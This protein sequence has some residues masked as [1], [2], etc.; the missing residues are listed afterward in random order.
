VH[1]MFVAGLFALSCSAA[2]AAEVINV[3]FKFTPFV[4]NPISEDQVKTVAGTARIFVNGIPYAEQEVGE[5]DVPVMFDER[6]IAAAVWLPTQSCG[7]LLRKGKNTIRIE[8]EPAD[9][10]LLYRAQFR[11]AAVMDEST[12]ASSDGSYAAT[13]QSGE[14]GEEKEGSGTLAFEREFQADFAVDQPWHHAPPVTALDEGDRKALAALVT[15]RVEAFQ[16]DFA[17][18]YALLEGR[19]GIDVAALKEAKC[20]DKAYEAGARIASPPA[21]E[22]DFLVTGNPEVVIRAKQGNLFF[23]ADVSAFQRITDE[24]VQMCVGMAFSAIY[25]PRLLVVRSASGGWQVID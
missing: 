14:G 10:S 6:E 20:L 1:R 7:S 4:G 25:P 13:N 24:D 2:S 21:S 16:P 15:G 19:E 8:F 3:E 11:W 5:N 23:P 17:K 18:I 9:A 22:V 12:E